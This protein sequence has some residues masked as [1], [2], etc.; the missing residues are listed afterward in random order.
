MAGT[1]AQPS[2][3]PSHKRKTISVKKEPQGV[4]GKG[5]LAEKKPR[6]GTTLLEENSTRH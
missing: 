6:G 2:H 1:T 3:K 5:K 4:E